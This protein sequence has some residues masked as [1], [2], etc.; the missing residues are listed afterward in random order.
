MTGRVPWT[1]IAGPTGRSSFSRKIQITAFA[2]SSFS[3]DV[4][5]WDLRKKHDRPARWGG[6]VAWL[7]AD[8]ASRRRARKRSVSSG[9]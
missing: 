3:K 7:E 4:F 1:T 9:K 8:M 5:A 6:C 2:N